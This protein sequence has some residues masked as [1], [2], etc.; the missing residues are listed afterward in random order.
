MSTVF[1]GV[2]VFAFLVL[3]SYFA[4]K[5][6]RKPEYVP[7]DKTHRP[8]FC[9]LCNERPGET[10]IDV[11]IQRYDYQVVMMRYRRV[12]TVRVCN[13]CLDRLYRRWLVYLWGVPFGILF[14]AA[15]YMAMSRGYEWPRSPALLTA[16]AVGLASSII[17]GCV[18]SMCTRGA[19]LSETWQMKDLAKDGWRV[20]S[21][22]D[23]G[24]AGPVN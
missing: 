16:F 10:K 7:A 21:W 12:L 13:E 14:G 6:K 1:L 11:K 22:E 8:G 2:L 23:K 3:L 19:T 18:R 5:G 15:T 24:P 9:D 20:L 4:N 17:L